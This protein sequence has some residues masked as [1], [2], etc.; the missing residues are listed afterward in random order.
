M[1]LKSRPFGVLLSTTMD[2]AL[3]HLDRGVD[4]LVTPKLGLS[5]EGLRA[6]VMGTYVRFVRHMDSSV[7]E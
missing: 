2:R 6:S 7:L 1:D 4:V 3:E 5:K